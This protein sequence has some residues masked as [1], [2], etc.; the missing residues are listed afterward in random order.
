[1]SATD[2]IEQLKAL[3]AEERKL[4]ARL[5]YELK[6]PTLPAEGNGKNVSGS[7]KWPHF[8]TRLQS[9]YGEKVAADSEAVISYA[10]GD[11]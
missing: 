6:A 7:G 11:W 8:G 4:F 5:F 2:L 3:P 9:I 1:M 10:R